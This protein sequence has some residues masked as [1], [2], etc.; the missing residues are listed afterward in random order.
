MDDAAPSTRQW[1]PPRWALWFIIVGTI[2]ATLSAG[3]ILFLQMTRA[4][5][6]SA[7]A[8]TATAP[9]AFATP[10]PPRSALI[11][12]QVVAAVTALP[13]PTF[14]PSNTPI[15]PPL[16]AWSDA[17]KNVLSWLCYYE[18][19]GMLEK[20]VDACLSVISTVRARYAY[21]SGFKE[22]D[23]ISTLERPG[24]FTGVKWD[25]S[26]PAPDPD[27]LWAVNQYTGG[28]RG[29][30]SGYLYF[31]SIP[32]GPVLCVIRSSNGE[33]MDFHNGWN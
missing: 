6:E 18:V 13:S 3:A 19:G 7:P 15:P 11:Q 9:L 12:R 16:I 25:T 1:R 14:I 17:E 21:K 33:F 24:Q 10:T 5:A 30:C 22:S 26:R 27:L 28:A 8:D 32:G 4:A 23:V 29:S 20:K 2:L 31:D